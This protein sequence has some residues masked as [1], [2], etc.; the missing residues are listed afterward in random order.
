MAA[1]DFSLSRLQPFQPDD[2][3]DDEDD[4]DSDPEYEVSVPG[5]FTFA[6][7]FRSSAEGLV[8]QSHLRKL[9]TIA[10]RAVVRKE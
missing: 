7:D 5:G 2:D 10:G 8:V 1:R 6:C 4:D 9:S 3:D